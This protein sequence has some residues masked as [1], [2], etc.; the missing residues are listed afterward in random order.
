MQQEIAVRVQHVSKCYQIYDRPSDRLKQFVLPHVKKLL[1]RK[2][3]RYFQE[4]WALKDISFD[5]YKGETIG[6][7]GKNGSGKSTLLQVICGTLTPTEGA[8]QTHGRVAAL[9]E[10]G[11]GFN[12]E[13]TGRENIYLSAAVLGLSKTEI[14]ARLEAILTFADIGFFV[15]QPVKIYSSGMYVKLAFAIIAHI[16][17]DILVIDEALAV[18][19]AVFIQKCMRFIR[20]FQEHGTLLFVSHDAASVQ[21]LCKKAIW[22]EAGQIQKYGLAPDVV[23]A[24]LQHTLQQTYGE[25]IKLNATAIT[26][27]FAGDCE[28]D[29]MAN[30]PNILQYADSVSVKDNLGAAKGWKTGSAEIIAIELRKIKN[31]DADAANSDALFSGGEFVRLTIQAH[32]K[33]ELDRPILGFILKDRL[34]QDLFGENTLPFTANHTLKVAAGQKFEAQFEFI[35]PMLPNGEYV[36]MASVADGDLHQNIQHHMMHDAL[37]INVVSSLVRWGLVGIPFKKASLH[38]I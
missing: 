12:P 18:G 6:I 36:L 23:Q 31:A 28:V 2:I 4:Y 22:L 37:V 33:I 14:D 35:L 3:S 9:L 5:L 26:S 21:N 27:S 24:Y 13:F 17:A 16:D 19:D 15:D 8:V 38:L 34:G 20:A 29:D 25:N 30:A 32:T 10:L 11:S 7:I 1:G